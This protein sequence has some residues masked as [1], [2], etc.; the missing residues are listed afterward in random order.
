MRGEKLKIIKAVLGR[1]YQS[2]HEQLFCCP[3]CNHH[4]MKMSVNVDKSVFKCWICDKSGRDLG[5]LVRK[6][7]TREQRDEW[8]KYDDQV[9]ITDFDF[10]FAEPD[11]PVEQRIDLPEGFVS[12]AS[13]TPPESAQ[14]ALRY[15]TKRGVTKNDIL[16]W[17]IGFC[18]DGEYTGRV[19]IPSFNENGYA[20]Y[21]VARSYD[22]EW[23]KYKNPPASRDIIFNELYVNWDEDLV[24]VEG[25]FDAIKAGN[26]IPLLGSTLR[27]GSALFQ[28]I[29]KNGNR[30]YLALDEDASKKTRSI[31]RLLQRYG[32]EVYEIDTSGVEDVG[33]M[34][35]KDF[36]SRKDNAAIVG[37]DNYLLQRLFA[38]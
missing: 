16:K 1:S 19:V 7:G 34:S 8:S 32:V 22:S 35:K 20:N 10:L 5:Y 31:I 6:F 28:A 24:I 9:E 33:D 11:G 21:Y 12:L 38:V 18:K 29:V 15:L 36:Q 23:P 13:R 3:F 14:T 25:V 4:K 37:K 2:G 26:G 30:V 17:K 27:E